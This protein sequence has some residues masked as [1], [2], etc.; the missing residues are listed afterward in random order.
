VEVPILDYN[1]GDAE[2]K[3][4]GLQATKRLG[5][6]KWLVK[7]LVVGDP[8]HVGSIFN[9]PEVPNGTSRAHSGLGQHRA[10]PLGFAQ[11]GAH[12]YR[13]T[14]RAALQLR[15]PRL[16]KLLHEARRRG[17]P[18]RALLLKV[19]RRTRSKGAGAVHGQRQ[20]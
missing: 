19:C 5:P 4:L 12:S 11:A 7:V 6:N 1:A 18:L 9:S 20:G 16:E 10:H 13:E 8:I 17:G 14:T 15:P 3:Q 2:A